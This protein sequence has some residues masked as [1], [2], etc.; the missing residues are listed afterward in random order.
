MTY[1]KDW[2]FWLAWLAVA[3]VVGFFV[4]MVTK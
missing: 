4:R 2:Q 3:L 1:I